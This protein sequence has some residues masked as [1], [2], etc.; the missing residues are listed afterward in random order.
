M[1]LLCGIFP[2]HALSMWDK[3]FLTQNDGLNAESFQDALPYFKNFHQVLIT[4]DG[5]PQDLKQPFTESMPEGEKWQC[6]KQC[7][8]FYVQSFYNNTG[9]PPMVPHILYV[10]P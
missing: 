4:W 1:E 5:A 3:D 10:G 7:A 8:L 2:Q 9:H 6:M